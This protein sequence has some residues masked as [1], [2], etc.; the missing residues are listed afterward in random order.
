[1]YLQGVTRSLEGTNDLWTSVLKRHSDD[2]R[3]IGLI[4]SVMTR[5]VIRASPKRATAAGD[6]AIPSLDPLNDGL[7]LSPW[8]S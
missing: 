1:M 7:F 5:H 2:E 4:H 6:A 8:R 3:L